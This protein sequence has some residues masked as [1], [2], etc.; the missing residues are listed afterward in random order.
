MKD[1]KVVIDSN[2]GDSG[3]GHIV[4]YLASK[5]GSDGLVIRYN[6]GAQAGHT[7][8]T[9]DGIRHVFSHFGS[10]TLINRPTYL[11][12]FFVCHPYEFSKEL[13]EQIRKF[14][15]HYCRECFKH[16]DEL[17][18]STNRPYKLNIHHIDYDKK[19]NKYQ[20]FF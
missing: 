11:S 18:T 12:R 4:D 17:R 3:K 5:C 19:H 1:I 6:S 16:Q 13:K 2:W 7:V 9:P 14:D 20:I 10:G 8:V 15:Y